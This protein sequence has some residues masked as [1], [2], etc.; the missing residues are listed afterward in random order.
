MRRTYL[1]I[2]YVG[3][4]EQVARTYQL[5]VSRG[6]VI[7]GIDPSGPAA[8]AGLRPGDIL[9]KLGN[10][11]ITTDLDMQRLLR[12]KSPGDPLLFTAL[13]G[14]RTLTIKARLGEA[15]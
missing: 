14:G 10:S 3:L 9:T 13:R 5:P 15:R 4:T 11:P 8:Q 1:G 2:Q 12:G 6:V 7:A